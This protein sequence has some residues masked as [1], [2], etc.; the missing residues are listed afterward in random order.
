MNLSWSKATE[1][2]F[3]MQIITTLVHLL[4]VTGIFCWITLYMK[5]ILFSGMVQNRNKEKLVLPL[6]WMLRFNTNNDN[7]I[8]VTQQTLTRVNRAMMWKAST[9][10]GYVFKWSLIQILMKFIDSKF[11]VYKRKRLLFHCVTEQWNSLLL[12]I[13]W[14]L[15]NLRGLDKQLHR[16]VKEKVI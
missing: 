12:W 8:K 10:L 5:W 15:R 13:V 11:K 4:W 6:P 14:I 1:L 3:I 9:Q 16:S 2:N 7:F